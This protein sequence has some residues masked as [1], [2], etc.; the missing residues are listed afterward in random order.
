MLLV[1]DGAISLEDSG[2]PRE[3]YG[4]TVD[5]QSLNPQGNFSPAYLE[6]APGRFPQNWT[7]SVDLDVVAAAATDLLETN[8]RGKIDGV[9]YA[10]PT[11]LQQ[12]VALTGPISVAGTVAEINAAGPHGR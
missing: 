9:V 2:T 5:P 6:M 12:F 1:N 10:D 4:P 8:G 7:S 3:L 11:A